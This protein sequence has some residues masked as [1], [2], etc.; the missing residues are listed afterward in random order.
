MKHKKAI[1]L[2]TIIALLLTT[3]AV[4]YIKSSI[5]TT[6]TETNSEFDIEAL[7]T[8]KILRVDCG[9][10][11]CDSEIVLDLKWGSKESDVGMSIY[12][13]GPEMPVSYTVPS[14]YAIGR[15]GKIYVADTE[16]NLLKIFKDGT[17]ISRIDMPERC[18]DG[19]YSMPF[20]LRDISIDDNGNIYGLNTFANKIVYIDVEKKSVENAFESI[21]FNTLWTVDVLCDSSVLLRDNC[22]QNGTRVRRFAPSASDK[23]IFEKSMENIIDFDLYEFT[24]GKGNRIS[25]TPY[26]VKEYQLTI[27]DCKEDSVIA[28][29]NFKA[30]Q[31]NPDRETN[32]RLLGTDTNGKVYFWIQYTPLSGEKAEMG[33]Q[34]WLANSDEFICQVDINEQ[35]INTCRIQNTNFS[36]S[37]STAFG[38]GKSIRIDNSGSVYQLNMDDDV[39]QIIK[40]NLN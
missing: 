30:P 26:G 10:N 40:Y 31:D 7:E 16:N 36:M 15:D 38:A 17:L 35:A 9:A 8:H 21:D 19:E 11:T 29:T 39:Y 18:S 23:P 1:V 12:Q 28:L 27:Y 24:D 20:V 3:T 5:V 33:T 13:E 2:A 32:V 14:A 6:R 37:S 22:G 34:R 4:A 25:V